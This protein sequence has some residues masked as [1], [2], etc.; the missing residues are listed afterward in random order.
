MG[1]SEGTRPSSGVT[2]M[3]VVSLPKSC[4]PYT[5]MALCEKWR[6]ERALSRVEGLLEVR[7]SDLKESEAQFR[8]LFE[9]LPDVLVI[10]DAQGMIQHINTSGARQLGYV[11]S[12]LIGTSLQN[13]QSGTA[14]A[15][16]KKTTDAPDSDCQYLLTDPHSPID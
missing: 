8:G 14:L 7:T 5:L 6:W 4:D 16:L 12:D 13:I 15:S 11:S 9:V 1:P 2:G 3:S 10:H